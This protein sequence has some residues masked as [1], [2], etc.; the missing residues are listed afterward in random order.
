MK[1]LNFFLLLWV[2]FALLDP[3][4]DS[5]S[6]S[7]YGYTTWMDPIR[8]RIRNTGLVIF[9]YFLLLICLYWQVWYADH[10]GMSRDEAEMEYLKIAQ[11]HTV[12]VP[13]IFVPTSNNLKILFCSR[14]AAL[15]LIFLSSNYINAWYTYVCRCCILI[16][17]I[18]VNCARIFRQPV[19]A[20]NRLGI[21]LS[22]RPARLHRLAELIPSN[23]FLGYFKN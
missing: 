19:G 13:F 10:R 4:P 20:R 3:V 7:E 1:F 9:I 16:L 17:I 6:G 15:K 23:Q 5:Q 21:D 12:P 14:N 8:I 2:I 18:L 11:V 22:Y